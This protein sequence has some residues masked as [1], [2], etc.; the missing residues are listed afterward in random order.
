MASRFLTADKEEAF[1]SARHWQVT[2]TSIRPMEQSRYRTK[3]SQD[4]RVPVRLR[5]DFSHCLVIVRPS[6]FST[7]G[8]YI[9]THSFQCSRIWQLGFIARFSFVTHYVELLDSP[10]SPRALQEDAWKQSEYKIWSRTKGTRAM[11]S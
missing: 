3:Q 8:S 6:S 9:T 4:E 7:V 10:P 5:I 1:M 11:S 2:M